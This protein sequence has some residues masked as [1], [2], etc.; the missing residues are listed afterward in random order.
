MK[1]LNNIMASLWGYFRNMNS[2]P[3]TDHI[4]IK[5]NMA[6]GIATVWVFVQVFTMSLFAYLLYK[7][8]VAVPSTGGGD[9]FIEVLKLFVDVCKFFN[10]VDGTF[11]S[12]ALGITTIEKIQ[13]LVKSWRG[14][15]DGAGPLTQK[16]GEN[17]APVVKD[18]FTTEEKID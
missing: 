1:Q 3:G 17:S 13:S 8:L 6:W 10:V 18:S 5:R 2:E 16:E 4:S 11:V 14:K 7:A 15:D 9:R 12:L